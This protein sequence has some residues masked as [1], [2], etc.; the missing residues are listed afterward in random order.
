MFNPP[1]SFN[2]FFHLPSI[3]PLNSLIISTN[4]KSASRSCHCKGEADITFT[5]E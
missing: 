1:I 5:I 4:K 2:Y 3:L